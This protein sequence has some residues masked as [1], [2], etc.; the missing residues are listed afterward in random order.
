MLYVVKG[1]DAVSKDAVKSKDAVISIVREK[2]K[3]PSSASTHCPGLDQL[4]PK[5]IKVTSHP[6]CDVHYFPFDRR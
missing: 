2:S 4:R 1:K 6:E 5:N 3:P